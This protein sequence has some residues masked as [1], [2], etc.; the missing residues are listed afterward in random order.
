M[1]R[2]RA[3]QNLTGT[4]QAG[5][6]LDRVGELPNRRKEGTLYWLRQIAGDTTRHSVESSAASASET[7][8]PTKSTDDGVRMPADNFL[9]SAGASA[10]GDPNDI[11]GLG[12]ASTDSADDADAPTPPTA[13][14]AHCGKPSDH[15]SLR[16][17]GNGSRSAWLH[18][19]CEIPWL[20]G[21]QV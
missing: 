13:L 7:K 5:Y 1:G 19:R 6:V 11:N 14:C 16:E 4:R 20:N 10:L 9:A 17:V 21:D 3:I 15:Q 18:R 8:N 2:A 12:R